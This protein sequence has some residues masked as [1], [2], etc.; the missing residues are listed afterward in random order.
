MAKPKASLRMYCV[1][2]NVEL[3]GKGLIERLA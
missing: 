2:K 3:D 1:V